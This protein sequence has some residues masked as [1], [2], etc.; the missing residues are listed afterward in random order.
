MLLGES[1]ASAVQVDVVLAASPKAWSFRFSYTMQSMVHNASLAVV[2][3]R[4][5]ASRRAA[6]CFAF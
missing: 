5:E 1:G 3:V 6:R 4:L 2:G